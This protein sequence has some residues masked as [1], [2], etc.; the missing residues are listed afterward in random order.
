M[1]APKTLPQPSDLPT[2]VEDGV[3]RSGVAGNGDTSNGEMIPTTCKTSG[4]G[5]NAADTGNDANCANATVAG[6]VRS[7]DAALDTLVD[8]AHSAI[9]LLAESARQGAVHRR[10]AEQFYTELAI[11]RQFHWQA[12]PNGFLAQQGW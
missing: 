6:N 7:G 4:S 1:S 12:Q 8:N 10:N 9:R 2:L 5:V 11:M 3:S